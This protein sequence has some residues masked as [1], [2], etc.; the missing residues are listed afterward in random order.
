MHSE[1]P[2]PPPLTGYDP[3]P[4]PPL[5]P[6]GYEDQYEDEVSISL[7]SNNIYYNGVTSINE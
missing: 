3:P 4:P 6:T 7:I 1:D 2:P 5:G